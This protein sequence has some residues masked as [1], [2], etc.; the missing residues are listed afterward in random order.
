[1]AWYQYFSGFWAGLFLANFVPHFVKGITGDAFPTPFSN[2]P[3]K[4]LSS[5][6][7]NI[8]WAFMNLIVALF[9]IRFGKI[10]M[11]DNLSAILFFAGFALISIF[12][13]IHFV[14]KDKV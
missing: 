12:C 4:G 14:N 10:S 13:S 5:P 7:I 3:G 2:P 8:L 6:V 9:L 11:G 1:M